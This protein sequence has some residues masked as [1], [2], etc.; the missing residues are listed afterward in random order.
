MVSVAAP[1]LNRRGDCLGALSLVAPDEG[2]S[3]VAARIALRTASLAISR[4]VGS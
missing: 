1:I 2:R 3:Q 4:S